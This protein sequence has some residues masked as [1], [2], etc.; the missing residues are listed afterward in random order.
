MAKTLKEVF[1]KKKPEEPTIV[2]PSFK[3]HML[4]EMEQGIDEENGQFFIMKFQAVVNRNG[5]DALHSVLQSDG[6]IVVMVTDGKQKQSDNEHKP[7]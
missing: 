1:S 4:R 7:E 2:I 6:S 3:L 5:M